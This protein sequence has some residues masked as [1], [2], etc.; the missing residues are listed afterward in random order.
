MSNSNNNQNYA[1]KLTAKMQKE[2]NLVVTL[3]DKFAV[4]TH[5]DKE[6]NVFYV[7]QGTVGRPMTTCDRSKMWK[8]IPKAV[9][10]DGIVDMD[11]VATIVALVDTREEALRI[12]DYF[13]NL[14]GR[15]DLG[16]GN[17]INKKGGTYGQPQNYN[18]RKKKEEVM[19]PTPF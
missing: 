6:G 8:S 17:L 19:S 11:K 5:T 2:I 18:R 1:F 7:G 12:E 10:P 9:R 14:Y 15:R 13:I 3:K 4:Y 16:Q